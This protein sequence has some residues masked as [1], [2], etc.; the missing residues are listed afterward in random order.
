MTGILQFLIEGVSAL[1][2]GHSLVS[3]ALPGMLQELLGEPVEM[4]I[5]NGAPLEIQ[6]TGPQY[7]QGVNGREWLPNH[8]VRALVITER[9]P[10]ASAADYHDTAGYAAKWVDLARQSN[11]QVKPYLYETWDYIEPGSTKPWRDRILADLPQWQA[12]ADQV[13]QDLAKGQEPMRL[14]PAGLGMV[15]LHDAIEA[16]RVP[17]ATTIRDFFVDDIHPT[18]GGGFYYLAMIHY[19]VLTGESPVGLINQIPGGGGPYPE[20]P[21][22]QAAVLQALAW[23][24]VQEFGAGK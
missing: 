2:I 17:G 7:A 13:N 15:R 22:D 23:E 21:K 24:T 8:P 4:Q 11:P 5:I 20:V 3:P 6:W 12:I 18:E 14:I 10:L 1:Y 19:A 16:G 9:V